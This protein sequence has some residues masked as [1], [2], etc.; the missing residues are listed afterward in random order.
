MV[1]TPHRIRIKIC[2]LTRAEDVAAA[3]AL[4][5][6]ALG[7]V[8]YPPSP[9]AVSVAAAAALCRDLPPF[10]SVVA[11]FVN[12]DPELVTA[13]T[14]AL[15]TAMLQ[16]HG[17]ESPEFCRQFARPYLKAFPAAPTAELLLARM[18]DYPDA[19]G[20]LVD[21]PTQGFGGSGE[22]FDWSRLPTPEARERPLI[23]A[24]GL[25]AANVGEAITAVRP[26]GVDVSSGVEASKGVKDRGKI[27]QFVAAV[28]NAEQALA[29][30]SHAP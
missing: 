24:G 16:F 19:S 17:T 28:R 2:G 3:A 18:A 12:P 20:W 5:A 29:L 8:F 9:R 13:V 6:D 10:V 1:A 22:T 15:P 25:N 14:T 21:T 23:L 30:S 4:G 26:W 7:F 11:L 27:A